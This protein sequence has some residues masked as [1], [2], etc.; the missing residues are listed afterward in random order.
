M[1][2]TRDTTSNVTTSSLNTKEET[3]TTDT[4]KLVKLK[5]FHPPKEPKALRIDQAKLTETETWDTL[6]TVPH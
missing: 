1:A 6:T 4:A 2:M 5:S 3:T